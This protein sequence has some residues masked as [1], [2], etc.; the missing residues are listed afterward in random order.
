MKRAP[1]SPR[2]VRG[3][4]LV[5]LV[6]LV[7]AAAVTA[8]PA[9]AA[10]PT[11]GDVWAGEVAARTARLSGEVVR[12]PTL[13][14]RY[15]FNLISAAAYALNQDAG[16][17][18]FAGA[19]TLPPLDVQVAAGT[20]AVTVSQPASNLQPQTAY[21]YRLVVSNA[22]GTANGA[23]HSLATQALGGGATLADGRGWEMV[24]PAFKNGGEI[25]GPGEVAGGG[26]FQLVP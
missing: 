11:V 14:G 16:K 10:A 26:V 3:S 8:A 7:L 5:A 1:R 20:G 15:H 24:S 18:P 2:L 4:R 25:G 13:V 21:R 17:D 23:T 22:S 12:D 19:L 9:R 6:P